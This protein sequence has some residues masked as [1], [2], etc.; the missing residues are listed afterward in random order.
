MVESLLVVSSGC[1]GVPLMLG[2]PT[3][4]EPPEA[5]P[6]RGRLLRATGDGEGGVT[7]DMMIVGVWIV[8][9]SVRYL[10]GSVPVEVLVDVVVVVAAAAV[11]VVGGG[12]GGFDSTLGVLSVE[13]FWVSR[14][15]L[16]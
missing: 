13:L 2:E 9:S 10:H 15:S 11:V 3:G 1:D 14:W 8:G 16:K 5:V 4:L 12:G 6:G 7:A